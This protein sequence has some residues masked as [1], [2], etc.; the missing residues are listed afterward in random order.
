MKV[1]I[2][3]QTFDVDAPIFGKVVAMLDGARAS[4]SGEGSLSYMF[5]GSSVPSEKTLT[6]VDGEAYFYL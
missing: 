5:A 4:V 1:I 6:F 2:F 3:T